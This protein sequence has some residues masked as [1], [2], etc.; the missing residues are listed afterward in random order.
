MGGITAAPDARFLANGF[1][2]ADNSVLV[3]CDAGW[4]IPFL[5]GRGNIVPPMFS[6]TKAPIVPG[7]RE[8]V[9]DLAV[10]TQSREL[11]DHEAVQLLR[12]KA[13]T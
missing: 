13:I 8:Q 11:A 9:K 6:N 2:A 7:F 3:G 5:T 1:L 10:E 12:A 4:W